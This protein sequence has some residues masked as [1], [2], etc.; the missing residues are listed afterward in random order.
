MIAALQRLQM[1]SGEAQLPAEIQ[2]LGISGG[3]G[4]SDLF[5]SHP[6]LEQR[7]AAL[8]ARD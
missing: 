5:R 4:L 3:G 8:Q 1:A 2:A 6:P 7:I